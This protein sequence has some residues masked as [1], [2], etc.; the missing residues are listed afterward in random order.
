MVIGEFC[1][2]SESLNLSGSVYRSGRIF[3]N[4]TGHL[5]L[6]LLLL[7]LSVICLEVLHAVKVYTGSPVI[8]TLVPN[9][10]TR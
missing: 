4:M 7:L 3:R 8:E 9:I 1:Y 10:T 6:L 2:C 5:L